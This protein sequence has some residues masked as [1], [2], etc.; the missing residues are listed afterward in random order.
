MIASFSLKTELFINLSF[1]FI[2]GVR[3]KIKISKKYPPH[4]YVMYE[5]NIN[6]QW[7]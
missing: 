2:D 6:I 5:S 3:D 4:Y 7:Q 1:S